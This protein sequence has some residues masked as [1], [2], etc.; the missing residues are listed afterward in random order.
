MQHIV[1][2]LLTFLWNSI[3]TQIMLEAAKDL[4]ASPKSPLEHKD[5]ETLKERV[6]KPK[7]PTPDL[8]V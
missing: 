6:Q 7:A 8:A 1:G 4:A 2:F 3:K 5:V